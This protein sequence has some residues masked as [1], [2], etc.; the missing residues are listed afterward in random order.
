LVGA[1]NA[2][3]TNLLTA[4]R[5][6]YEDNIKFDEKVDFP[7]FQVNDRESWMDVSYLLTNEEFALL[8]EDYKNPSNILKVRKYLRSDIEGRVMAG[9]SNIFGYEKGKLSRNLFYGA[10]NFSEAKFGSVIYIPETTVTDEALKLTGPSPL[11]DVI[12]FIVKKVV[13]SSNSFQALS[14]AFKDFDERFKDE[15]SKEGFSLESLFENINKS[16]K[17]WDV[18]FGI[19]INPVKPEEIVKSLVS[20]HIIDEFLKEEI[21]VKNTGQGLQRHLMYTLLRISSQYADKK[22]YKKKEFSPELTLMLFEEPE[23]FLHPC[24]QEC[25]NRSLRLLSSEENQQIIISTHSPIFVSKNIEDLPSLI[26]LQRNLGISNIY[27]V[28]ETGRKAI[29][30]QNS[31]L[32]EHLR[33]KLDDQ[34]IAEETKKEI[35]RIL[36]STDDE[37]RMEEESIRLIQ[38]LDATRCSAF[39]ADIVLICE[40]ATEK[41]LIEYLLE[42][43]W[44]DLT[45]QR[46][47]VLDVMGKYNIHRYMN[48]FKDLGIAH[49]I[50]LDK[51]R[52][53]QVQAFINDFI[54]AQKNQ[55]TKKIYSFE[56]NI[57]D[58][59]GIRPPPEDRRDKKPLNVL[60]HYSKGKIEQRRIDALKG[61]VKDLLS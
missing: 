55:Y 29:I 27:Q 36:G 23:A 51:D 50:L 49:S 9:Q 45:D 60:W 48:L 25:L 21:N 17:E 19:T 58:F 20:H 14:Q 61:I 57:E 28:S 11:R 15:Q 53:A 10:K 39:F 59:L 2:G 4:L 43:E 34:S 12:N 35:R 18:K 1:N 56:R 42:N 24:Q 54:E 52:D 7:K 46:A 16:L 41:I 44:A 47:C 31:L 37:T 30:E 33:G 40:G 5:I 38:W 13:S 22:E 26:K 6:F 3:K 8:K 32:A